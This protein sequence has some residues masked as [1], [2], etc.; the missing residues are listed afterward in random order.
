[1][2]HPGACTVTI[3]NQIVEF[4]Y[5]NRGR[6]FCYPCIRKR[7]TLPDLREVEDALVAT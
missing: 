5:A 6:V 3:E 4:L 7:L 2:Q 1:M